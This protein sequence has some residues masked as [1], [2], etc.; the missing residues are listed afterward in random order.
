MLISSSFISFGLVASGARWLQ[1]WTCQQL[2]WGRIHSETP[3]WSRHN[4]WKWLQR[5]PDTTHK[6]GHQV[7]VLREK[8]MHHTHF[9]RFFILMHSLSFASPSPLNCLPWNTSR[10]GLQLWFPATC[11]FSSI[12]LFLLSLTPPEFDSSPTPL[13]D[14][15]C[16]LGGDSTISSQFFSR[17]FLALLLNIPHLSVSKSSHSEGRLQPDPSAWS[18]LTGECETGVGLDLYILGIRWNSP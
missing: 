9:N 18:M 12:W 8:I 4:S 13:A 16:Q 6:E 14:W 10:V 11:H 1:G 2:V 3:N 7:T 15:W 17:C 5:W